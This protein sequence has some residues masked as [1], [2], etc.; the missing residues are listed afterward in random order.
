MDRYQIVAKP[1]VETPIDENAKLKHESGLWVKFKS[2]SL[3]RFELSSNSFYKSDSLV[4]FV[5]CSWVLDYLNC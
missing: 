1:K 4:R 5:G 2:H 3:T